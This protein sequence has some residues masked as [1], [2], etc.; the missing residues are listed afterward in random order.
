MGFHMD[1]GSI[2]AKEV[3]MLAAR[4]LMQNLHS[5][6]VILLLL[7]LKILLLHYCLHCKHF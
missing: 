5:L 7:Q 4:Y 1:Y 2:Q 6:Q 3:L